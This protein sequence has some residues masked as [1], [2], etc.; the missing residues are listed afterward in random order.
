MPENEVRRGYL[1]TEFWL[2]ALAEVVGLLLA[3]GLVSA[4]GDGP[5]PKIIGG[6][7]AILGALGYA[8]QRRKLKSGE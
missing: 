7:I 1:T 4:V 2:T 3:S 8:V 6:A 5:W